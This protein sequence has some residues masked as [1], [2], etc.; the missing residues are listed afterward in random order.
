MAGFADLVHPTWLPAL[1]PHEERLAAIARA[2]D[3]LIEEHASTTVVQPG[4]TLQVD[5]YGNLLI[6][7]GLA[8][9]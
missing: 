3:A 1:A 8:S 2:V 7:I 9:A 6:T 4:D 5:D